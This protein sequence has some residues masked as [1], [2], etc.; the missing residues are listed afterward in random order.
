[1]C[2]KLCQLYDRDNMKI[3]PSVFFV[4]VARVLCDACDVVSSGYM[5]AP[6]ASK[7]NN[8]WC[9]SAFCSMKKFCLYWH[10][11]SETSSTLWCINLL[12]IYLFLSLCNS[13]SFLWS[14]KCSTLSHVTE[15]SGQFWRKC[16]GYFGQFKSSVQSM[17]SMV[18]WPHAAA[19]ALDWR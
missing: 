12:V 10:I 1:M 5:G 8:H 6:D 11:G 13:M 4:A 18:S 19:T 15:Q 7:A 16:T 14:K 2:I 9:S 17:N 3:D